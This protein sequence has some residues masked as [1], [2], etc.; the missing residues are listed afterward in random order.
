MLGTAA[1]DLQQRGMT[2]RFDMS[3][4][5]RRV[6]PNHRDD[7][8][9]LFMAVTV[10]VDISHLK[11]GR[12]GEKLLKIREIVWTEEAADGNL[13]IAEPLIIVFTK[14]II[15]IFVKSS[16]P[17]SAERRTL[18]VLPEKFN[19]VEIGNRIKTLR[20]RRNMTI[21]DLAKAA[22]VSAGHVSEIERGKSAV[23][24]EKL[25]QLA[26]ALAVGVT[27]LVEG[28]EDELQQKEVRIPAALSAAADRLDLSHRATL[29]LL[30]GKQ[31]LTARRAQ[32]EEI[33]WS[34]DEWV[35]FYTQVKE[36]L[37]DS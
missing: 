17:K 3:L 37:P 36:F 27:V 9:M 10:V 11:F 30:Q 34:T 14:L 4:V 28:T 23:S 7:D 13:H 5:R 8:L 12:H 22:E 24:W 29:A 31:S 20:N 2:R 21:H 15:F 19:R 33:E 16:S 26:E 35:R 25:V 32:S 6:E 1:Q 18:F